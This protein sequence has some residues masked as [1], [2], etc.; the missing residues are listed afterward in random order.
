MRRSTLV[1]VLGLILITPLAAQQK[2]TWEIGGFG[3]YTV[4]DKS[5]SQAD[6]SKSKNSFGAGGRVGYFLSDHFSLELDGSG[7]ATDLDG[8]GGAQSVGMVYMPFHLRALYNGAI[9]DNSSWILGGGI[10]Y[11]RYNVSSAADNFTK[12]TFEG[13]DW[14]VGALAGFRIG[15]SEVWTLRVDGTLDYIPS[16]QSDTEGSNTMLGLQAGL[17]VFLGGKCTDK[18]DSIAV[19]P[20]NSTVMVGETV[21][22]TVRGFLCDGSSTNVTSASVGSASGGTLAGAAFSSNTPGSYTI[23]YNNDMARKGK[24]SSATVTVNARLIPPVTLTRVD[25]QPD[26]ATI[27]AGES[28][29]LRVVGFY[30][31]GTSRPVTC[32]LTADAGTVS[33]GSFSAGRAGSYTVTANCDGGQTDRSRI[34]VTPISI[35]LRAMFEFNKTNVF[36]QAERDSLKVLATLLK[37]NPG[38]MLTLQGHTDWVGGVSY[39]EKLGSQ[40]IAAVLEILKAEGVSQ[41][42]LDGFT[43]TSFG[44]CQQVAANT[45]KAGRDQNRRVEIT[46]PGSAKAYEGTGA[47][48]NRP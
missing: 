43:K 26:Q 1:A 39:N 8:A 41:A 14:G 15:L 18:L 31:D 6:D 10:N 47:C 4:Y 29:A 23:S 7:N 21:N 33:N 34:T 30:S 32:Q 17:G 46:D 13:S 35:T 28:V 22:L 44:E 19:E 36:V 16:P 11:N 48:K 2:G 20:R 27:S 5:F 40:R 25:L 42:Q 12:K 38:M 24:A 37:A 3:R 45:T 9:G